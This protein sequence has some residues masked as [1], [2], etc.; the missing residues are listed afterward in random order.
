M[1]VG[2]CV[3]LDAVTIG[4]MCTNKSG[5]VNLLK[6][7]I[8]PFHKLSWKELSSDVVM[9]PL[10]IEARNPAR[11]ESDKIRD[12]RSRKKVTNQVFIFMEVID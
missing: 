8:I 11:I 7:L 5:G 3:V 12:R 6:R 1:C 2:V 10:V 9:K 4:D